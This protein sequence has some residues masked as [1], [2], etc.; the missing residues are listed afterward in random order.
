VQQEISGIQ[1]E[2]V[3]FAY[4]MH[5][6]RESELRQRADDWRLV[7][8]AKAARTAERRARRTQARRVPA[9]T[10]VRTD[11][12]GV[13]SSGSSGRPLGPRAHGAS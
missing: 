7:R 4:E 5:Q 2:D 3:M 13:P 8:D 11:A 6:A 12:E 1:G 9:R 10:A